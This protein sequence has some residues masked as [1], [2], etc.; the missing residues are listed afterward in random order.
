M[1]PA[2]ELEA[3]GTSLTDERTQWLERAAEGLTPEESWELLGWV[4]SA[5]GSVVAQERP[6]RVELVGF[7]LS[8]LEDG[9]LDRREA[10]N[11]ASLVHR[12][13]EV[14]GYDYPALVTRGARGAG[15]LG[16][17]ALRW[18]PTV[19][20]ELPPTHLEE[21]AGRSFTFRRV[22]PSFD[23]VALEARLV[24]AQRASRERGR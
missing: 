14:A 7:A 23:P 11:L 19:S 9:P 16:R 24:A 17:R 2:D 6:D 13:C 12:A 21:G 1:G 5:A 10:M 20:P 4:E 15:E 18:L 3:M 8:L 22:P